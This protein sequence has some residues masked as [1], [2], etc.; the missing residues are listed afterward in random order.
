MD[1]KEFNPSGSDTTSLTDRS[2]SHSKTNVN[3]NSM[4]N[5]KNN[6]GTVKNP[7][8]Q[9]M[10]IKDIIKKYILKTQMLSLNIMI[11]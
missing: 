8:S 10:V 2:L 11:T 4:Q 3:I 9:T 5:S 1:V 6:A 7:N